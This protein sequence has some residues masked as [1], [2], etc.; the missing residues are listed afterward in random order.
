MPSLILHSL[1]LVQYSPLPWCVSSPTSFPGA[2]NPPKQPADER[3]ASH[4]GYFIFGAG[5]GNALQTPPI[6]K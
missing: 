2:E 5:G 1:F 3:I 4:S 6:M